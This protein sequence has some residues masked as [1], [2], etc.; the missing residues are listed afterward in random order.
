WWLLSWRIPVRATLTLLSLTSILWPAYWAV[1]GTLWKDV[2]MAM[3][4]LGVVAS[5]WVLAPRRP[6]VALAVV[7][8]GGCNAALVRYNGI[9]AALTL[10]VVGTLGWTSRWRWPWSW[11]WGVAGAVAVAQVAT[12]VTLTRSI[13]V[14]L[15]VEA[16]FPQQQIFL[17]DLAGVSATIGRN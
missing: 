8:T 15:R 11:R 5:A 3:V 7:F 16:T 6:G 14:L 17:L 2:W 10:V 9:V 4:L 12:V 1:L 13:A